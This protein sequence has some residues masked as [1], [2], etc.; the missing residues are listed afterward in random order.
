[1]RAPTSA[2]AYRLMAKLEASSG[3]QVASHLAQAEYYYL[4]GEPHSAIDQLNMARRN[5]PLDI[6]HSSRI[7]A[8]LQQ[9]KDEL[10]RSEHISRQ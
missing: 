5:N 10:E 6:Y 9:I 4:S 2:E 7:D 3:N 1:M 8:R